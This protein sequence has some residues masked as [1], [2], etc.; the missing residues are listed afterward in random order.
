MNFGALPGDTLSSCTGNVLTIEEVKVLV[1]T[2][3]RKSHHKTVT[4]R[5]SDVLTIEEVQLLVGYGS[6]CV[7]QRFM[8]HF[9]LAVAPHCVAQRLHKTDV[10]HIADE[11]MF[12]IN[13]V[14]MQLVVCLRQLRP[15]AATADW[16]LRV[17]PRSWAS[18]ESQV[19]DL[20]LQGS[21]QES[22]AFRWTSQARQC[23]PAMET[24]KG[25]INKS[26]TSNGQTANGISA[27]HIKRQ[28]SAGENKRETDKISATGKLR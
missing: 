18:K 10:I 12:T 19:P 17:L 8:L 5:V 21:T 26:S 11:C 28:F 23:T 24:F 3:K 22:K 1:Y 15:L 2:S 27:E 4:Y 9:K 7:Q 6:H 25:V 14:L 13:K 16:Q 20:V